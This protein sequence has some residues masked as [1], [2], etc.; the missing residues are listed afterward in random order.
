M[1]NNNTVEFKKGDRVKVVYSR[2]TVSDIAADLIG[3]VADGD[4]SYEAA[5]A[6]NAAI[7]GGLPFYIVEVVVD[8]FD[9][10]TLYGVALKKNALAHFLLG[11]DELESYV[12]TDSQAKMSL[13]GAANGEQI[14]FENILDKKLAFICQV[15]KISFDFRWYKI[16]TTGVGVQ[17]IDNV[18]YW[19]DDSR[20]QS[21][22]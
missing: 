15:W 14:F 12:G 10:L 6:I 2:S 19:I 5:E 20:L 1:T 3:S 13:I 16:E 21:N 18:P 9:K 11:S 8:K 4:C 17:F 7:E 22:A